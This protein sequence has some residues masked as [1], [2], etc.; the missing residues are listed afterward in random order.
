MRNHVC[1][2]FPGLSVRHIFKTGQPPHGHPHPSSLQ[3]TPCFLVPSLT[4]ALVGYA[5]TLVQRTHQL[6]RSPLLA[7]SLLSP[8]RANPRSSWAHT[9]GLLFVS[10]LPHWG[11]TPFLSTPAW[12]LSLESDFL[13]GWPPHLSTALLAWTLT[14]SRS[15][16][17]LPTLD[18]RSTNVRKPGSTWQLWSALQQ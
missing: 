6:R 4:T 13:A 3:V 18:S 10:F 5:C 16:F 14:F 7:H 17:L 11:K 9:E 12:T 2:L 1:V 8:Q 15:P